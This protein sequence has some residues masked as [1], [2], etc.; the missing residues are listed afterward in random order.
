MELEFVQEQSILVVVTLGQCLQLFLQAHFKSQRHGSATHQD[1]VLCQFATHIDWALEN[2]IQ[3]NEGQSQVVVVVGEQR[4][5]C[6]LTKSARNGNFDSAFQWI[7]NVRTGFRW[8]SISVFLCP[9]ERSN[10]T[11]ADWK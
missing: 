5:E 8:I 1:H 11:G 4:F 6:G 2:R 7:L 10:E 9:S 3:D